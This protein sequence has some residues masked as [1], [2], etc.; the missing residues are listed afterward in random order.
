MGI[1]R[2]FQF[3]IAAFLLLSGSFA[4]ANENDSS[5]A[6]EVVQ[7]HVEV[8]KAPP[9]N[10]WWNKATRGVGMFFGGAAMAAKT[11]LP[12]F[13][14]T[15]LGY[16]AK[17]ITTA[18]SYCTGWN[19]YLD[20]LADENSTIQWLMAGVICGKG[21][22]FSD[23]ETARKEVAHIAKLLKMATEDIKAREKG[24]K[25][26]QKEKMDAA[27]KE[28]SKR[29]RTQGSFS[30]NAAVYGA[31]YILPKFVDWDQDMIAFATGCGL[32]FID[33]KTVKALAV[34]L[35]LYKFGKL[36]VGDCMSGTSD[37]MQFA[38]QR[39][40]YATEFVQT[41][42]LGARIKREYE[43]HQIK[44]DRKK[45]QE[46]RRNGNS[47]PV[48]VL[49]MPEGADQIVEPPPVLTEKVVSKERSHINFMILLL[50]AT[51]IA[52][53]MVLSYKSGMV[54]APT[55]KFANQIG[56]KKV[57]VDV[58]AFSDTRDLDEELRASDMV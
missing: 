13:V 23:Q 58:Y 35:M 4:F 18:V 38:K 5:T 40:K 21:M 26:G 47:G 39:L 19:N 36:N 57:Q 27:A 54:K 20:F 24:E 43:I 30:V 17:P 8:D 16:V 56:Q 22:G 29:L 45:Q 25:Y 14:K 31:G 52:L 37:F 1:M 2:R 44:E 55:S 9:G 51:I 6:D 28:L 50:V 32:K 10:S 15:G 48:Q 49:S 34:M 7:T 41:M 12:D 42:R 11:L 33:E 53:I 3:L 46:F